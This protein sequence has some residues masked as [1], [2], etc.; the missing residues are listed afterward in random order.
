MKAYSV[1]PQAKELKEL[2]IELQANTVYSFF[3]SISTN[4]LDILDK[5]TIYSDANAISTLK[6]PFFIGEQLIVGDALILGKNG[7]LD[8]EVTIPIDDLKPLINYDVSS[9]HVDA[10]TLLKDS[11]INLYKV[12][13]VSKDGENIQL[14][15]EWVLHVFSIADSKTQE[16]FLAELKKAI[17]SK[18]DIF[19]Y[20]QKMATIALNA[21]DNQ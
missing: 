9:L 16:Y 3:N 10:L 8:T 6:T 12:F 11:D 14:S 17:D 18:Q 21:M 5:H 20:M 7:F 4:E 1:S 13:E 19:E 2:E 15:T